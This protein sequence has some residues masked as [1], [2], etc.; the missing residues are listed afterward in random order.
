MAALGIAVTP[1]FDSYRYSDGSA[2]AV[3]IQA[4]CQT[5]QSCDREAGCKSETDC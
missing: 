3:G 5:E 2:L 1:D 4:A